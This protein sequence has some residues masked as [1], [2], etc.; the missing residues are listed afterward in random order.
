[1][2]IYDRIILKNDSSYQKLSTQDKK[3]LLFI[4]RHCYFAY[5]FVQKLSII[6]HILIMLLCI[7]SLL[8][9]NK[10]FMLITLII[11]VCLL[12]F[13]I[14]FKPISKSGEL[15]TQ[16]IRNIHLIN[17]KVISLKDWKFIKKNFPDDYLFLCTEE[18]N[19]ECYDST[20][21]ITNI[22]KDKELTILWLSVK[23]LDKRVGHAIIKRG[24]YIY[25]SNLRKTYL[26]KDYLEAFHAIT[27][28]E[29]SF[30]DY[31]AEFG[32][33]HIHKLFKEFTDWC[34]KNNCLC[35]IEA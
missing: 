26:A 35:S 8:C 5:W 1:M 16:K 4:F 20:L 31:S 29:L 21:A 11:G 13:L 9:F 30:E 33:E 24:D 2:F 19:H 15:I 32:T 28:K 7:L 3:D 12:P 34:T 22:L 10:T 27:Y 14:F 18:C 6:L 25:D 23:F 17:S